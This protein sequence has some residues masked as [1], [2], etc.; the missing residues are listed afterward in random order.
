MDNWRVDIVSG[1]DLRR[2][3]V[4]TGKVDVKITVTFE[5]MIPQLIPTSAELVWS[6]PTKMHRIR[7]FM[8]A[9]GTIYRVVLITGGSCGRGREIGFVA[10]RCGAGGVIAS[11]KMD[12]CIATAEEIGAEIGSAAAAYKVQ[13]GHWDQIDGFWLK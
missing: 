13:V 12:K 8:S 10:A 11:R 4:R 7:L 3:A 6:R 2:G 1:E 9:F 5:S